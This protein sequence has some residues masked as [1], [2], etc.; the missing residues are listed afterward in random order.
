M[1]RN[2]FVLRQYI[3][4]YN[5]RRQEN[6]YLTRSKLS[7]SERCF[8]TEAGAEWNKL[9]PHLKGYMSAGVFKYKI[10][11]YLMPLLQ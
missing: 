7:I 1:F 2:S 3:N 4:S 8:K 9:P 6:V 10:Q 11:N 5:T